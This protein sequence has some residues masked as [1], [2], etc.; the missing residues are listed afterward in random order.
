MLA[1]LKNGVGVGVHYDDDRAGPAAR[2]Q[3]VHGG[4]EVFKVVY[5]VKTQHQVGAWAQPRRFI[6]PVAV[7][8]SR[9]AHQHFFRG[10]SRELDQRLLRRIDTHVR[11][12]RRKGVAQRI[13]D[14]SAAAAN[15]DDRRHDNAIERAC[16]ANKTQPLYLPRHAPALGVR[17]RVRFVSAH[18][19]CLVVS[20]H[21]YT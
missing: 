18:A 3:R 11:E 1:V 19:C 21:R 6:G 17:A 4:A 12:S 14:L 2:R 7:N 10:A 16:S 20:G 13:D 5:R 15:V 9:G 8:Q